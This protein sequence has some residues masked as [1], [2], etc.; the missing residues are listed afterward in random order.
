MIDGG[1]GGPVFGTV[2]GSLVPPGSSSAGS[3]RLL[4]LDT[5]ELAHVPGLEGRSGSELVVVRGGV[6]ALGS[7]DS[8]FTFIASPSWNRTTPSK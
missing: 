3:W 6:V 2:S 5:G 1:E 4:D 8:A 7:R